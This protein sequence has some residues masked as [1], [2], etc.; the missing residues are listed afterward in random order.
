VSKPSDLILNYGMGWDSTALLLRWLEEPASRDCALEDLTVVTAQVGEEFADTKALVEAHILPRLRAQHIRFVQVAR[1]GPSDRDGIVVLDDSRAPT[2]VFIGGGWTLG[3]H[4]IRD[5]TVPQYV[6]GR[7]FCA[8]RFKGWPINRFLTQDRGDTP[9]RSVLGYNA[10]EIRR[11]RKAAEYTNVQRTHAFPLISWGWGHA[12]VQAYV[13]TVVGQPWQKSCCGFCPFTNGRRHLVD[14]HRRFPEQGARAL[15]MELVSTS[16]N[17][18]MG[19]YPSGERLLTTLQREGVGAALA[20][21][22]AMLARIPW[23]LYHVRRIYRE[24]PPLVDRSVRRIATGNR[25]AM[26]AL[27]VALGINDDADGTPRCYLRRRDGS[28]RPALEEFYVTAPAVIAD[29][30]KKLFAQA[31][32]QRTWDTPVEDPRD[33]VMPDRGGCAAI[34]HSMADLIEEHANVSTTAS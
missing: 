34:Q 1:A 22:D 20:H 23:A 13:E 19:L 18:R 33:R 32:N 9:Y 25:E 4:M 30:E 31:W 5:G 28:E 12:E 10:D 29:K 27:L 11:S 16:L 6:S 15:F 8:Q 7:H 17:P 21:Y 14:R 3:D 24:Q 2:E 26:H